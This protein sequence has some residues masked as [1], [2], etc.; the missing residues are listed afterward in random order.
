[1]LIIAA[2]VALVVLGA[3]A[4]LIFSPSSAPPD[5][6]EVVQRLEDR[7]LPVGEVETYNAENDPNKLLGRPGQYTGK[8]TF[9]DTG[10]EPD[11]ITEEFDVQNGGSAEVF[12]TEE[13]AG[14]REEYLNAIS[15]SAPMFAE[16]TYR[17]DRVLLRLSHSLTPGQA[18]EYEDALRG[19]L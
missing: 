5:A 4:W 7:G 3:G 15:E 10:L 1:M 12:E 18:E 13:D 9:K 2:L 8:A 14:R 6:A 16:Y 17:E 19:S 11:S